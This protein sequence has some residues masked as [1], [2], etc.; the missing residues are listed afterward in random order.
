MPGR[1]TTSSRSNDQARR[2]ARVGLLAALVCV[3][4][5]LLWSP[6]KANAA[7]PPQGVYEQCAPNSTTLDCGQRLRTIADAGFKYVLNYTAWFGNAQQ[8]RRY[9]DQAQAAGIKLIWPLNDR[10]WRDGTNLRA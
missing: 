3:F 8:V 4:T 9:A 7:I 10:A 6:A 5:F 1:T 2:S